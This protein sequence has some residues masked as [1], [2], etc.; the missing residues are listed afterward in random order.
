MFRQVVGRLVVL[1]RQLLRRAA[2]EYVVFS[3]SLGEMSD[4]T[5]SRLAA[6]Y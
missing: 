2:T 6:Q 4:G 5:R 3:C 1:R